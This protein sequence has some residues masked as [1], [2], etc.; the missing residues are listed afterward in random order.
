MHRG[1]RK[2]EEHIRSLVQPTAK[3]YL[4]DDLGNPDA[5]KT[6]SGLGTCV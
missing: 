4:H 1:A 2:T 3:E 5:P 6:I